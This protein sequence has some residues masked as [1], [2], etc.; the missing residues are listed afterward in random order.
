[1]DDSYPKIPEMK[2]KIRGA[3]RTNNLVG[4]PNDF[5]PYLTELD[6]ET[7]RGYARELTKHQS[8]AQVNAPLSYPFYQAAI[9]T[10]NLALPWQHG[11]KPQQNNK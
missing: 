1:M 6:S 4:I 8:K 11:N 5:R 10:L 3:M 2:E 7:C 9:D